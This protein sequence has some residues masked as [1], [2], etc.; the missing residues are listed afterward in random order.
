M[1]TPAQVA[2]KFHRLAADIQHMDANI[3]NATALELKRSVQATLA[4]AAPRGRSNV[5]KKGA[6]VGVRYDNP[7][8]HKAVVR[9]T[10]PAH[11]LESDTKSHRIPRSQVGRGRVRRAN[12]KKIF[13]PGVGVRAYAN[14]PGTRG[15]HPWAKGIRLGLPKVDQV[16]GKVLRQTVEKVFH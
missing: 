7:A 4:M 12:T 14:H 16:G 1:S 2:S 3:L 9:M 13:I 8:P 6:K 11:L 15:K 5:G 10:G